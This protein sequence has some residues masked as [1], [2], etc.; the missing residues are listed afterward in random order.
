MRGKTPIYT[1]L[2]KYVQKKNLRLH[3]PGHVGGK[4]ITAMELQQLAE[5]D[6]TEIEEI[7]DLHVF[8]GAIEEGRQLLAQA[9]KARESLFLVNGATSGIHTLFMT[10]GAQQKVVVP[11]SAHRSF[12][13]GMVL[14]GV[15]PVYVPASVDQRFGISMPIHVQDIEQTIKENIDIQAVFV[16][17]P[18]YYGLSCDLE[19]MVKT[20]RQVD[21][22]IL[23]FVDEAHG[24]HFPFHNKYPSSA[25]TSGADAAVNGLHKTLPVLNQGGCLHAAGKELFWEKIFPAWSLLTTTSPSFPILASID[26]AR[27]LMVNQGYELLDHALSMA[28]EFRQKIGSI[29]GLLVY[30]E[31]HITTNRVV[32]HDPLKVLIAVNGLSIN[33]FQTAEILYR[34]YQIQIECQGQHYVLAMMSI[35]H[36]RNDWQL[37]LNALRDIAGKYRVS[38][39]KEERIVQPP[40]PSMAMTPREA[41]FAPKKDVDFRECKGRIAGEMI[42][43][44]PPGIPCVLPGERIDETSYN[45]LQEIKVRQIPLHGIKDRNLNKIA[46]ID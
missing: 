17:S 22:K 9:F 5:I 33:G 24:G 45:Y 12:Y 16:V 31:E 29:K 19:E 18:D 20:I 46:V 13:E 7:G 30:N 27:D 42:A 36:E 37:L 10:L 39:K 43:P 3:M 14:S 32:P 1:A 23:I 26:L 8:R 6:V 21:D 11:R 35:F 44:Y 38:G 25:I 15:Q 40:L 28:R 41:F 4:G 34:D 2:R